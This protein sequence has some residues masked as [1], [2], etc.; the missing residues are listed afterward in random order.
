MGKR[1]TALLVLLAS[2]VF[3]TPSHA[4]TARVVVDFAKAGL[5]VG[6]GTGRGVLTH[7]GRDYRFRIYG[8]S[9]GLTAGASTTRFEGH[10]SNLHHL[11]DFAGT[12][13]AVGVGG[14]WLLGA[15]DVRLTN[16][17]GVT[18]T[19]H[20]IRGGIELSANISGIRIEFE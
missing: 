14:A 4:K 7:D 9:V 19:L 13:T 6:A 1:S 20:G 2:I 18:I 17:K 5:I 15:G 10:A 12:Y 11:R 8:L 3:A 16:D